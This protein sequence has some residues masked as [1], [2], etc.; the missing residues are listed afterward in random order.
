MSSKARVPGLKFSEAS[1][2][3]QLFVPASSA[4]VQEIRNV[5][6]NTPGLTDRYSIRLRADVY[7]VTVDKSQGSYLENI[8]NSYS[9]A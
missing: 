9:R 7:R 1:D 6:D 4:S 3:S 2:G 8:Y 5:L